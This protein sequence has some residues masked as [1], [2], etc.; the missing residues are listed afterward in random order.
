MSSW[1]AISSFGSSAVPGSA[2]K[3]E[4]QPKCS[5]TTTSAKIQPALNNTGAKSVAKNRSRT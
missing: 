1:R 4:V 3:G 5:P 2:A